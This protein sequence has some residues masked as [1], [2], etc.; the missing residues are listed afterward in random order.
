[1]ETSLESI[2]VDIK[3]VRLVEIHALLALLDK[4]HLNIHERSAAEKLRVAGREATERL[5]E[6]GRAR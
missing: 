3:G 2:K 5:M 6:A 1:M 4:E